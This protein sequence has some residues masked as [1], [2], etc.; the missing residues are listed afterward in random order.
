[1]AKSSAN[2]KPLVF[3]TR[4]I[5]QPGIDLI[6]KYARVKLRKTDSW[7]SRKELL[8]GVKDAD[9]LLPILTDPIDAKVMDA[10][11]N[12]KLIANYGAGY[13]NIDVEAATERGI[14]VTNT[15]GVL[16]DTTAESTMALMLSLAH[17]VAESERVMRDGKYP[18]WGPMLYLGSQ[19]SGKTLGIVGMGRIG[20]RV[21]EMAYHGFGMN[22]LY[23]TQHKERDVEHTLSAKK[24]TLP[25]L[26]KKSDFVSLHVPLT[27]GTTH[28]I[29]TKELR[30][31]KKEAYLINTARGPVIDEKALVSALKKKTIAGAA[32]DVYENEPKMAPGLA[33]LHNAVL[34]PHIASA[35][36]ETRTAMSMLAAKNVRAFAQRKP[37]PALVNPEVLMR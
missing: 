17:R 25:T 35:T 13:N 6:K 33:K 34:T 14:M 31:M 28:M 1:M 5:P 8:A 15:P 3:I 9:I 18:G 20:T 32:L 16:T 22:I 27:D 12:L 11:P 37:L 26:L 30:M 24:V 19:L 2:K 4:P 7:I 10:A 36:I 21:A 29:G 23:H